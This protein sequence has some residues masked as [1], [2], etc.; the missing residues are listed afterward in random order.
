MLYHTFIKATEM[1]INDVKER[2]IKQL[3]FKIRNFLEIAT[4]GQ[5]IFVFKRNKPLHLD[6]ILPLFAALNRIGP[7]PLMVVC[8]AS[9]V[10]PATSIDVVMPGL[11]V[12]YLT[13]FGNIVDALPKS[14]SE[15]IILCREALLLAA[16]IP[17]HL[18]TTLTS[19]LSENPK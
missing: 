19:E 10:H 8:P 5:K 12:G 9:P 2:Q 13:E 14:I 6:E 7:S 1:A 16:H 15:W 3:K 18:A 17:T 4:E 11:F